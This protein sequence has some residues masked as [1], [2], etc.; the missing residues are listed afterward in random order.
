MG[1]ARLVEATGSLPTELAADVEEFFT[2]NPVEEAKRALQKALEA[3]KLR[4]ELVQRETTALRK[5]LEGD[6]AKLA[7]A[8]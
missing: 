3:M 7:G 4:A 5:W 8:A 2:K 6:F 1:V